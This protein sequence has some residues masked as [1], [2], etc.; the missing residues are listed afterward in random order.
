M[1]S[2]QQTADS[3]IFGVPAGTITSRRPLFKWTPA[4]EAIFD[5]HALA[6]P[7]SLDKHEHMPQ[8]LVELGLDG[9]KGIRNAQGEQVHDII[10]R[11]VENKIRD[12]RRGLSKA[13]A[14]LARLPAP[15]RR[16]P[17]LSPPAPGRSSPADT[18]PGDPS[19]P[20]NS[21]NHP[22]GQ[23]L[24]ASSVP[25]IPLPTSRVNRLPPPA[26]ELHS[27]ENNDDAGEEDEY[28]KQES[29]SDDDMYIYKGV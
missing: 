23:V 6:Y 21:L 20:S 15:S 24:P 1:A 10:M 28:I 27:S 14:I 18:V 7:A 16:Q 29:D 2:N 19:V 13:N 12:T 26:P 17:I 5:A 4:Q 3:L 11:K 22:L 9:F 25:Q 8:L